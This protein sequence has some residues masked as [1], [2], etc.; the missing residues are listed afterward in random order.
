MVLFPFY[1][2]RAAFVS[3]RTLAVFQRSSFTD[4][5]AVLPQ[6]ITAVFQRSS[7]TDETAVLP[8][9][10]TGPCGLET[11]KP[12]VLQRSFPDETT[13]LSEEELEWL[14][15]TSFHVHFLRRRDVHLAPGVRLTAENV[16]HAASLASGLLHAAR[17]LP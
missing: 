2:S 9:C 17:T 12:A 15:T 11:R 7:F 1:Q 10:I 3:P 8:L 6:C 16:E 4:E 5:T 13:I 14:S